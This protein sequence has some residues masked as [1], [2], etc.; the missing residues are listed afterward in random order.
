MISGW[1]YGVWSSDSNDDQ[2]RLDFETVCS[3]F[4]EDDE[5]EEDESDGSV[6]GDE[7]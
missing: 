6:V 5:A 1:G 4:A 3:E 2:H 7:Q